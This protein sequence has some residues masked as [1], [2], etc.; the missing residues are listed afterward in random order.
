MFERFK[1]F[2]ATSLFSTYQGAAIGDWW[3]ELVRNRF[4]IGLRYLPRA[5][6]ISVSSLVN[7]IIAWRVRRIHG[8]RIDA[9]VIPPPVF[10]L[11]HWR[12]GT[13]LL[14]R[15]FALDQR[16]CYPT[17]YECVFPRGFIL[18]EA[19]NSKAYSRMLPANRMFDNMSNSF[20]SPAEDEF[21]LAVLTGLSPYTGWCF[22]KNQ[23]WYDRFLTFDSA[24]PAERTEW[25]DAFRDYVRRLTYHHGKPLILKSPP[26]TARVGLILEAF[27]EARFVHIHREP[28]TV[29]S[30]TKKMLGTFHGST[31]LQAFDHGTIEETVIRNYRV[32]HEALLRDLPKIPA[33]RFVDI[34]Y[35]RL[36][37][38]PVAV[39]TEI[40]E[41]LALPEF[42]AVEPA[43]R[44]YFEDQKDY[45]KNKH[46]DLPQA[47]RRR[48]ATEWKPFFEHW[49]YPPPSTD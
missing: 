7:S 40:Y 42:T 43:V 33:G 4:R 6:I 25:I 27:P 19:V 37:K 17:F 49:G 20:E 26:H 36:E 30:S 34:A 8:A 39:M 28:V 15:L 35:E 48:L 31:Q 24:T 11:G 38:E 3:R 18:S 22:P 45:R 47:L 2:L 23:A 16:F 46:P 44:Q 13:T 5:L 1:V 10:V 29:F 14:Q 41:R 12:S 9:T 32:T 21:A